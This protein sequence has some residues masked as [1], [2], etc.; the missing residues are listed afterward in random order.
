MTSNMVT[1]YTIIEKENRILKSEN[2]QLKAKMQELSKEQDDNKEVSSLK[3]IKMFSALIQE[4]FGSDKYK[5][6]DEIVFDYSNVSENFANLFKNLQSNLDIQFNPATDGANFSQS[7]NNSIE[8]L[9]KLKENLDSLFAFLELPSTMEL[10]KLSNDNVVLNNLIVELEKSKEVLSALTNEF[11]NWNEKLKNDDSKFNQLFKDWDESI[12]DL[13]DTLKDK[14]KKQIQ[15]I[16]SYYEKLNTQLESAT[17]SIVQVEINKQ[18]ELLEKLKEKRLSVSE[19]MDKN[20]SSISIKLNELIEKY[21]QFENNNNLFGSLQMLDTK[22]KEQNETFEKSKIELN[23][24]ITESLNKLN[25]G[26]K[27]VDNG[28]KKLVIGYSITSLLVGIAFGA[29]AFKILPL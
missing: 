1:K 10:Y 13:S 11:G 21:K 2:E 25:Q 28:Y 24:T 29:V 19:T 3:N 27:N 4:G 8:A 15:T 26:V 14:F 17:D 6:S 9:N 12:N 23:K 7:R 20:I 22:L 16:N 18:N 5:S